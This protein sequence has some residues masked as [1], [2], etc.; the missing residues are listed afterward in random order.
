MAADSEVR[1][2]NGNKKLGTLALAALAF[3]A[4]SG[5]PFGIEQTVQA[6]GPFYALL[7]FSTLLVWALPEAL[8]TAELST[9]LPEAAGSV[10]W[11]TVAYG[12]FWGFLKGYLSWLSGALD[13]SLY[14]ILFLDCLLQL[15]EDD[16]HTVLEEPVIRIAF[17]STTTLI[18]SYVNYRGLDIVGNVAIGLCVASMMPFAMLIFLASFKL[19]PSRWLEAPEG[20]LSGVDWGL[21]LNTFFWNI[22]FWESAACFSGDVA[23]PGVTFPRGI[24]LAVVFVGISSFLAILFSTGASESHYTEWSDGF[25][26]HVAEELGGPW[27]SGWM[28]FAAAI[29][30]IGLFEAEMSSDALQVAGMAD[31]GQLPKFLSERSKYGV[32]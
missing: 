17:V 4:V 25:F 23:N 28:M 31:R 14:P 16:E 8:I 6:G 20:G 11:V 19:K 5:G 1:S 2:V 26:V 10:A 32:H 21:L 12:D 24:L 29:S 15:V 18:L 3:Y 13:N 30:N 27:L 22:N 9:A 7:G